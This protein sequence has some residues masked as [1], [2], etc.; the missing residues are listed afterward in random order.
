MGSINHIYSPNQWEVV[1][2][3]KDTYQM[4][5]GSS[6]DELSF[7]YIYIFISKENY[8]NILNG[9]YLYKALPYSE[10]KIVIYNKHMRRI[11]LLYK[12]RFYHH[13]E[14]LKMFEYR[15]ATEKEKNAKQMFDE[16]RKHIGENVKVILWNYGAKTEQIGVLEKVNDFSCVLLEDVGFT[17]IGYGIAIQT[18]LSSSGEVLYNNP[19]VDGY[20]KIDAE[21]I[22]NAAKEMFGYDKAFEIEKSIFGEILTNKEEKPKLNQKTK[23]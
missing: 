5:I 3:N 18:I 23:R 15:R 10:E 14:D 16:L 17:F 9:K 19:Y 6:D 1:R 7:G 21:D 11:P 13:T 20:D 8:E 4:M 12:T 2:E 22:S